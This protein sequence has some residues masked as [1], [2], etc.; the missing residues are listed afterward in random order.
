MSDDVQPR[1]RRAAYGGESATLRSGDVTLQL[2]KRTTGWGWGELVAADGTLL[3]VLDNFGELALRDAPVPMRLESDSIERET[4]QRFV[5]DVSSVTTAD[6]LAGSSFERWVGVPFTGPA[7]T[8]Q[9]SIEASG[10]GRFDI[11]WELE[12][13]LDLHAKYLRGPWL[14]V[15]AGSFGSERDDAILPGIDWATDREWT[16]GDDWFRDPWSMRAVPPVDSVAI[17]TMVISRNDTFIALSWEAD[18]TATG[19]FSMQPER[20]QPVFA[21]PNFI[22]RN[23]SSLL[24]LMLPESRS[25]SGDQWSAS[26]P[27]ELH[28]GQR[29]SLA[30][31]VKVGRGSALD[32]VVGWVDANGM[33]DPLPERWALDEAL[34]RIARSY[35]TGLWHPG[36]GFGVGQSEGDIRPVVPRFAPAYLERFAEA[37][38]AAALRKCIESLDRMAILPHTTE[39]S[40]GLRAD[41]EELLQHQGSDG[42]FLFD[43]EGKHRSKDDFVVARD[44]V[45]PMGQQGDSALDFDAVPAI[46][47]LRAAESTGD[48]RFRAAGLAALDHARQFTRPE[49]GDFWETPLH[50]PNLF[51]AGHGA[52]AYALA[53]RIAGRDIDRLSARHWLRSI[54]P[55]THL[56]SPSVRPMLYNTK[57]C[58]CSSD[59]YFAN[60]VRDH[61]QWEVLET[62]ALAAETGLDFGSVD[63]DLDW[64]KFHAGITWAAVRWLLDHD[65]DNWRPHNL[66][67]S[68]ELYR[69]G[70]LDGCLPDTH[71]STTGRYGGMAIPA[72][73]VALNLLAIAER[74]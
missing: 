50:S 29:I 28:R 49:G 58:L 61:V 55:F 3:A 42:S 70:I 25:G 51:A 2:F 44:L 38:E 5:F 60:W 34:H 72:D 20:A 54:L 62:F 35:S 13:H 7:I 53:W 68:I 59:W 45:A 21:S 33:P 71:N 6:A 22:E 12:S 37:L 69:A 17:P 18:A 65:D 24:G 1:Y 46:T 63:P 67:D 32:G 30:A 66:P 23:D 47:L 26:V 48:A 52:V 40:E 41:A 27:L 64:A 43:P 14:R 11:A 31:R 56:W 57:P 4:G 39:A 73:V 10:D 36:S 16:S 9:V 19:W 15:G 8:G 74:N